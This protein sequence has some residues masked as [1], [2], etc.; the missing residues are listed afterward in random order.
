MASV[1]QTND[2]A[3][4][5]WIEKN[6]KQ[7]ECLLRDATEHF[8]YLT[9]DVTKFDGV[10]TL[11]LITYGNTQQLGFRVFEVIGVADLHAPGLYPL[12]SNS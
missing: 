12:F 11:I 9:Y 3:V 8:T 4:R 7:A 2:N 6:F 5:F 1:K 10:R